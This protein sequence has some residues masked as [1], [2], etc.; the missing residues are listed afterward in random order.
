MYGIDQSLGRVRAVAAQEQ[1]HITF[2]FLL[3]TSNINRRNILS[4]Q[5][6]NK[7]GLRKMPKETQNHRARHPGRETQE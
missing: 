4:H 2:T 1:H 7:H 3:P 6:Q 5:E